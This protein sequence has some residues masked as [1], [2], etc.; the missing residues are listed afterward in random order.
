VAQHPAL[1]ASAAEQ[2]RV[3]DRPHALQLYTTE[4]FLERAVLQFLDEDPKAPVLVIARPHV[5]AAVQTAL[6]NPAGGPNADGRRVE[7]L[8]ADETLAQIA[9]G[10]HV[11]A[12]RFAA[13]V[14]RRIAALEQAGQVRAFG[15]MVALLRERGETGKALEL[16][17]LWTE[18]L[19]RHDVALLCAYPLHQFAG[20]GGR[21]DLERVLAAHNAVHPGEPAVA[22]PRGWE[23]ALRDRDAAA[24]Q[25]SERARAAAEDDMREFVENAPVPLH[26]VD[27]D[28]RVLWANRAELEFLGYTRDEYVGMDIRDVHVERA[29]AEGILRR[30]RAGE[31]LRG[32]QV[33]L[34]RKDGAIRVAVL[35]SSARFE[36]DGLAYTRCFTRDV[37]AQAH[38][39]AA[40]EAAGKILEMV[41]DGFLHVRSDWV[42]SFAKP[43]RRPIAEG[44]SDAMVGKVLWDVSPGIRGSVFEDEYRA[45]MA[46]GERRTFTAF[47]EDAGLW[48]E[49]T[50]VPAHDG[51][52]IYYR[53]VSERNRTEALLRVRSHQQASV[54]RLGQKALSGLPLEDLFDE[55]VREVA[56][57]LGVAFCK[58]LELQPDGHTLLLRAGLGWRRGLVGNATLSTESG[59]HGGYTLRA[60][61]PVVVVD[62]AAETRFGAANLLKDHGIVSGMSVIIPGRVQ[63]FGVLGAH[64]AVRRIF[65]EDDIH[66]L[67]SLAHLLA[68][69]IERRRVEDEL[70]RHRDHLEELVAER[71]RRLA[72][73]NR[74]LEAFNYSVS[75]DLKTPL[76]AIAGLGGLLATRHRDEL[77]TTARKLLSQ[78]QDQAVRMGALMEDLMNLSRY[79]QLEL[80]REPVDVSALATEVLLALAAAHPDRKVTWAV[81][82]GLQAVGDPHLLRVVLENLLGNAWKF[83][84]QTPD[85]RIEVAP[86]PGE[87]PTIAIRDNGAGFDMG[88]AAKLFQ[89]FQRLH[90][91]LEFEGTGIG[92]AT[93]ARIVQRHGGRVWAEG[94]PGAGATF[95]LTLPQRG[96]AVAEPMASS[97]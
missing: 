79:H 78:V 13:V 56:E 8:D 33:R 77:S 7:T 44:Q 69:A 32:E 46:S 92:L 95:Y 22:A 57:T 48:L 9:G 63:P 82:P 6:G 3:P 24:M 19:S 50:I 54:S 25:W 37:T 84:G 67:Q 21:V 15:E 38:L 60:G 90:G 70:R 85:A 73:S 93:V 5:C 96:P 36:G 39:D 35:D 10:N 97:V 53:D 71:T 62:L 26:K 27:G 55:T 16:E 31:T 4:A 11:D 20:E 34:R 40:R 81:Q 59:S 18:A 88:Y 49:N 1:H 51:I 42:V 61:E 14:G 68:A 2:G 80:E 12:H 64:S 76:R 86:T 41:N 47:F 29:A 87:Q 43:W 45:G 83:T 30:L 23:E 74:E 65:T 75:H 94:R 91:P 28:G 17:A 66:Y 72:E 58:L 52:W 89:P